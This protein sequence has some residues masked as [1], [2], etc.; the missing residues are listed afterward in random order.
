METIFSNAGYHFIAHRILK[1]LD[2]KSIT[3]LRQTN[4]NIM[5]KCDNLTVQRAR[6]Q[7]IT[8]LETLKCQ[9]CHKLISTKLADLASFLE[10]NGINH[11]LYFQFPFMKRGD[12]KREDIL[13]QFV[14]KFF[15]I[16]QDSLGYLTL[17]E[18]VCIYSDNIFVWSEAFFSLRSKIESTILKYVK[19]I[20]SNCLNRSWD[21]HHLM[22]IVGIAKEKGHHELALNL[23]KKHELYS[24]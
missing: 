8:D 18:C 5:D 6:S 3:M 21:R 15:N 4:R 19:F 12:E 2:D 11:E 17:G 20:P 7:K 16:V 23:M 1:S 9:V 24:G 13:R 22:T 14:E 10:Q